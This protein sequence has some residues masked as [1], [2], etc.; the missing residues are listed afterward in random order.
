MKL[1]T[2]GATAKSMQVLVSVLKLC[3]H[4]FVFGQYIIIRKNHKQGTLLTHSHQS[5]S[6]ARSRR[7]A[8]VHHGGDLLQSIPHQPIDAAAGYF[9]PV[10]A[11][12]H[13]RSKE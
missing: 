7:P 8:I 10:D 12:V 2:R 3:M 5:P 6:T 11:P 1:E 13:K 9:L 4:G